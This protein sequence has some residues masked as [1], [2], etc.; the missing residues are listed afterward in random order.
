MSIQYINNDWIS[1]LSIRYVSY[2]IFVTTHVHILRSTPNQPPATPQ[3]P[4]RPSL[5]LW[6]TL[7]LAC[8][9]TGRVIPQD[10]AS[11]FDNSCEAQCLLQQ[12]TAWPIISRMSALGSLLC[13]PKEDQ[14]AFTLCNPLTQNRNNLSTS[15]TIPFVG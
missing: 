13:H 11:C 10:G 9:Q 2:S 15:I 7:S 5:S 14:V 1:T 3:H 6:L 4:H 12:N 8:V